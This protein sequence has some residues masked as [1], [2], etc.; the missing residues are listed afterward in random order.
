MQNTQGYDVLNKLSR[1]FPA[2]AISWRVGS[3]S[4]D[5][6]RGMALAYLDARDVMSRFDSVLGLNWQCRH[7]W[8]DS[9]KLCCEIGINFNGTW[10]W[11]SDG[12]GDTNVEA[13]KGAFSSAFKRAAVQFGVGRYLYDLPD[14][15]VP[16]NEWKQ[17]SEEEKTKLYDRMKKYLNKLEKEGTYL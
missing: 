11:R 7:T 1:P 15:W 2:E 10:I 16:L 3:L 4:K 5:K 6:T 17:I 8:S 12:A 9:Q 13:E 14:I